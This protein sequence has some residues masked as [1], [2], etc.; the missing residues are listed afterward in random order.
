MVSISTELFF[1]VFNTLI[2]MLVPVIL[3]FIAIKIFTRSKST[4][5]KISELE[6]RVND[7]ENK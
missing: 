1:Q 7:L 2:L 6:K 5:N 4:S 3:I